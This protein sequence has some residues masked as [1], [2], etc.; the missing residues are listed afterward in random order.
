[1]GKQGG[2]T[3][4]GIDDEQLSS[5]VDALVR[6]GLDRY[7]EGDLVGALSEWEHA[8][9]LLPSA[10]RPQ[11]YIAY[12]RKNF[13]LLEEQFE[14]ARQV[15][16]IAAEQ[17]V[18]FV[19]G[20]NL[21]GDDDYEEFEL[22]DPSSVK[23]SKWIDD[24][25]EGWDLEEIG[26]EPLPPVPDTLGPGLGVVAEGL[27]SV[28]GGE[29][30]DGVAEMAKSLADET[31]FSDLNM[32]LDAPTEQPPEK[33]AEMLALEL[34]AD[35]PPLPPEAQPT[36]AYPEGK[37]PQGDWLDLTGSGDYPAAEPSRNTDTDDEL[38][39]PG[40]EEPPPLADRVALSEDA[41][42]AMGAP[43]DAAEPPG[44]Q[45]PE[46]FD[47]GEVGRL[48]R[49][50]RDDRIAEP[51]AGVQVTFHDVGTSEQTRPA[52]P[53]QT[54][55]DPLE[56]DLG[57]GDDLLGPS[58]RSDTEADEER[59]VERPSGAGLWPRAFD[60]LSLEGDDEQTGDRDFGELRPPT[61]D[62]LLR[63]E[64]VIVEANARAATDQDATREVPAI[65]EDARESE[66]TREV[67]TP[68][69]KSK[70]IPPT[71]SK[72]GESSVITGVKHQASGIEAVQM[73]VVAAQIDVEIDEGAPEDEAEDDRIRRRVAALI[74]RAQAA[75]SQGHAS[76]A[77]VA[78]DLALDEKPESAIAQKI[79]HRHRDLLFEVFEAY[80]GDSNAMPT[81][82][83]PAHE[84]ALQE[85]DSRAAFLLSRIDG[86]LT[87]EEVLD[88]A[89]MARL[90]AYRH[91]CRLLLRG[92]LEVR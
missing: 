78:V 52:R 3:S 5:R 53:S 83:L 12:V 21:D 32:S 61:E 85:L 74:D 33:S 56:L 38:T 69:G 31:D 92:I 2:E 30:G 91:L 84:I 28:E 66:S 36:V 4:T 89:G 50:V 71:R 34:E 68:S 22:E 44:K 62:P 54:M 18:P 73:E 88:V 8:L 82:A 6:R 40:G 45:V 64:S 42:A 79:I 81:V 29:P 47:L 11:E 58:G 25:D 63:N 70:R 41:I 87:F 46:D 48:D 7:G 14:Q 13:D 23:L 57:D 80:V 20:A 90:E 59:T 51:D 49:S 77:V 75:M 15:A 65:S 10:P 17:G 16:A 35:E 24:V 39:V 43:K 60:D 67:R 26:A 1:M 27:T 72:G 19:A 55:A 37:Y 9:T 86:T 76:T